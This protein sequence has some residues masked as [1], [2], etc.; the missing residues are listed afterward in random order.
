MT[1]PYYRWK[2]WWRPSSRRLFSGLQSGYDIHWVE[3]WKLLMI[4]KVQLNSRLQEKL[5]E[6]DRKLSRR[7]WQVN[8]QVRENSNIYYQFKSLHFSKTQRHAFEVICN[9][10]QKLGA[11][12][13]RINY[14]LLYGHLKNR[15]ACWIDLNL[16]IPRS[17]TL[18]GWWESSARLVAY[19]EVSWIESGIN[20]R[21]VTP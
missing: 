4:N 20:S 9:S 7:Y 8:F 21:C 16:R 6:I 18:V 13:G 10:W 17:R 11:V 1:L 19:C 5:E 14:K 3:H 12:P 15:C 2:V